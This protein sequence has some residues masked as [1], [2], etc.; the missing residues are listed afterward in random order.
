MQGCLKQQDST[1][2]LVRATF[3][4][5]V[6]SRNAVTSAAFGT[7]PRASASWRRLR[8]I[9]GSGSF[10]GA[11]VR[12]R[13][14]RTKR[15]LFPQRRAREE[16]ISK[17]ASLLGTFW[18]PVMARN[19]LKAPPATL[20]AAFL[21]IELNTSVGLDLEL[22][23]VAGVL[24]V[25]ASRGDSAPNSFPSFT[26]LPSGTGSCGWDVSWN[27]DVT[28]CRLVI[29]DWRSDWSAQQ[30]TKTLRPVCTSS[31]SQEMKEEL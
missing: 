6:A 29:H 28:C 4:R 25:I 14:F 18:P 27:W 16:S 3:S 22:F 30:N 7:S 1:Q 11:L 8:A 19:P 12:I 5:Q 15:L 17:K 9:S 26:S 24:G 20:P 31:H 13:S 23:H 2:G 10:S 21:A